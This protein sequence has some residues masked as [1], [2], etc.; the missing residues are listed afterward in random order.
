MKVHTLTREQFL[1]RPPSEVFPFFADA[2]NLEAITPPLLGFRVVTERPIEMRAGALIQYRLRLRGLSLDWLT[3]ID[4][5]EPGVR[6]VDTQLAGPYR[7]WHHT[8]SFDSQG[9]GT[10]MRDVVR[11]ALPAW[12]LGELAAP[13]VRRELAAIFDFRRD[14]VG[15]LLDSAPKA[16][17]FTK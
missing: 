9:G 12:P 1:D 10:L 17:C 3:R 8:H 5:W 11:Y 15:R 14:A 2:H 13:L 16:T 7:L 4:E 6:F